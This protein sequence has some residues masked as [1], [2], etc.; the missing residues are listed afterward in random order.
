[1]QSV[2]LITGASRGIGF[3]VAEA[4]AA[5]GYGLALCAR[6]GARLAL[7]AR[8]FAGIAHYAEV[9]DV[10]DAAQVQAFVEG[11]QDRLGRIDVLVNNAGVAWAGEFIQQSISSIAAQVDVNL[12]GLMFMTRTV[13]PLMCAQGSGVVINVSSGAGVDG[14]EG[15]AAYGAS[16]FGVV[17]FTE[18]LAQELAP[19]NVHAY[20]VC[21]GRVATDM[22]EQVSGARVGMD[23]SRVARLVL[24]LAA[25]RPAFKRCFV[26]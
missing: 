4:F 22:Q 25:E 1:M 17:G 9:C 20:A 2:A 26:P 19:Y 24:R 15:L 18:A 23:S 7:S 11:T 6:D 8:K 3:A 21:P 13:A 16:K 12:K 10:T 14:I 5:V